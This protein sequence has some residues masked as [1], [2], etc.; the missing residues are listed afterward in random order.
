MKKDSALCSSID[1]YIIYS[2]ADVRE[3]LVEL[4]N[5]INKAAPEAEEVISFQMP[6]FKMNGILVYFAACKK[7]YRFLSYFK[8][9]KSI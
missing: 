6:A 1:E 2:S 7:T 3:L 8:W 4:R 5:T 9:Y